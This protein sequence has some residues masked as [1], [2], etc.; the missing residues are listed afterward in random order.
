MIKRLLLV[1]SILLVLGLTGAFIWLVTPHEFEREAVEHALVS[2]RLVAVEQQA[3]QVFSPV[4][5]RPSTGVIFYPG[6]KTDPAT[7]APILR[8]LARSGLLV[9][10]VPMPL[11]IAFLGIDSADDVMQAYPHIDHWYL[12]GH[13]MG[14][15]A[16]AEYAASS[17]DRLSGLIL[18]ASYP[19]SDISQLDLPVLSVYGLQDA[20]TTVEDIESNKPWLPKQARYVAVDANHWAFGHYERTPGSAGQQSGRQRAQQEII[21]AT[22][23]FIRSVQPWPRGSSPL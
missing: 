4:A 18:W 17:A 14:G 11:K 21:E 10:N 2:D 5:A 20:M 13:S 6:G 19:A 15:V 23:G 8:Q 1:V 22:L 7:Y 16:A 12:A 3:F 9:I